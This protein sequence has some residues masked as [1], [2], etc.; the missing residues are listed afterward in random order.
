MSSKKSPSPSPN[1]KLDWLRAMRRGTYARLAGAA[2][3]HTWIPQATQYLSLTVAPLM[4]TSLGEGGARRVAAVAAGTVPGS[5]KA[6]SAIMSV[7]VRY[8][9]TDATWQARWRRRQRLGG[10]GYPTQ[11]GRRMVRLTRTPVGVSPTRSGATRAKNA[12]LGM[13]SRANHVSSPLRWG[14]FQRGG[15]SGP[16]SLC[17]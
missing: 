5:E 6:V 4:R 10:Q 9:S 7:A 13:V 1:P 17:G 12:A 2:A 14:H 8:V 3:R 11:L 16:L 15:A